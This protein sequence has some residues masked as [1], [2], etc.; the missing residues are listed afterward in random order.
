MFVCVLFKVFNTCI[1]FSRVGTISV[2]VV[3]ITDCT[4]AEADNVKGLAS[5][6]RCHFDLDGVQV[7][8]GMEHQSA[9]PKTDVVDSGT[10]LMVVR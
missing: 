4:M 7:K 6:W 5:L 1:F 9:L 8:K 3:D 10:S 2:S